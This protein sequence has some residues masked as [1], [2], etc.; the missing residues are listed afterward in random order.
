MKGPLAIA[1]AVLVA[2]SALGV[3]YWA[4]FVRPERRADEAPRAPEALLVAESDGVVEVAGAD[5]VFHAARPG[6]RLYARDRI[7]T[8]DD[9]AALLTAAD[10]ARVRISAATEARVDELN[11]E[12][13]RLSLGV[14]MVEADVPDGRRLLELRLDELGAAARTRGGRFTASSN[15]QGTAAV[16]SQRGEVILSARGREV[17]IRPGQLARVLR[18]Q[19]PTAP[20][21]IPASLFLKVAWPPTASTKQRLTVEG[22]TAAG[23]RVQLGKKWI[24]VDASGAYRTVVD[25]GDGVH[26]LHLH[27]VDVA[28]HVVDEKS[29]RI[30]VDTKT[31]FKVQRPKWK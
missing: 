1:L 16:A 11:R 14:G 25:L 20:E 12:L 23:A 30:V 21:T 26:E 10:G 31:D 19:A 7:R 24:P 15:G 28:G 3:S 18:G 8:G 9:G 13:E 6:T 22:R 4:L 2:L 27:A 29:P 5:G 17:V